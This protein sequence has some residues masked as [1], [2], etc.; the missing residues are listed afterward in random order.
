[1]S[2][3]H[4]SELPPVTVRGEYISQA[5]MELWT[6]GPSLHARSPSFMTSK[7][8]PSRTRTIKWFPGPRMHRALEAAARRGMEDLK[9][10]LAAVGNDINDLD[11]SLTVGKLVAKMQIL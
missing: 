5:E 7:Q 4:D 2:A 11:G 10:L 8:Q 1:M 9:K 3:V 6:Y